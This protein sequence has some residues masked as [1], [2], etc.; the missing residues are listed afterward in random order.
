MEV[1][2][3]DIEGLVLRR[4]FI[5]TEDTYFYGDSFLRRRLISTE[6]HFYAGDWFPRRTLIL[7]RVTH[8]HGVHLF[9]AEETYFYESNHFYGVDS[10]QRRKLVAEWVEWVAGNRILV[11]AQRFLGSPRGEYCNSLETV[12]STIYMFIFSAGLPGIFLFLTRSSKSSRRKVAAQK[13]L[14][15]SRQNISWPRDFLFYRLFHPSKE[16][17]LGKNNFHLR[18]RRLLSY[19][20]AHFQTSQ[21]VY[22]IH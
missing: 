8:F 16:Q 2:Q 7:T 18:W 22:L 5:P 13:P 14:D 11:F 3:L 1:T 20:E 9:F 12:V 10:F 21:F 19:E 15:F 4:R 6:A 17:Q